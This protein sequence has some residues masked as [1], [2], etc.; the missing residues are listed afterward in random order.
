MPTFS[1]QALD[2]IIAEIPAGHTASTI[3]STLRAELASRMRVK[4][5]DERLKSLGLAGR[6]G[7]LRTYLATPRI[8]AAGRYRYT[9][10][11]VEITGL[12][13]VNDIA[14]AFLS[15]HWIGRSLPAGGIDFTSQEQGVRNALSASGEGRFSISLDDAS[16]AFIEITVARADT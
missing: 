7:R 15:E 5:E 4:R 6:D 10:Q 13:S 3:A 14:A 2:A 9:G 11:P 16:G 8:W 12:S 1:D